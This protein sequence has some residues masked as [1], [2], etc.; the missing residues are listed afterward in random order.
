MQIGS[1]SCHPKI[2]A[3]LSLS[4]TCETLGGMNE[5]VCWKFRSGRAPLDWFSASGKKKSDWHSKKPN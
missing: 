5:S 2:A 1:E 4:E 3:M